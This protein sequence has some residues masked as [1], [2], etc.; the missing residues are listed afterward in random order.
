MASITEGGT[1]PAQKPAKAKG[2][3][4]YRQAIVTRLTHWTWAICL[5]FLLLT[6]LNIFNARP[7]L[8]WGQES[9]FEYDNTIFQIGA[10]AVDGKLR[11]YTDIGGLKFDT[12]GVLGVS[13]TE[14]RPLQRAF[15]PWATIPSG[16]D[17]ATSRVV[18]FFF[19]WLFVAV[20]F[21]WFVFS[22]FNGHIR[23]DVIPTPKDVAG[24]P[25]DV[26]DHATFKFKHARS[27]SP[28]Q[29][30]TYFGVFFVLFP[31]IILTG[32][33]MSPGMDAAWPWL[34][35]IFG[36]RQTARTIHFIVMVLLVL[37][38]IVHIIMVI[39]A[40]PLNE[41]RSMITGYYRTS[42]GTEPDSK[43]RADG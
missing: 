13:G 6:G 22:F 40:G 23:R 37:F 30:L 2:P 38:F 18:H 16:Y 11:G 24:L 5:F 17:L 34:L 25:Q 4:I 36:G 1:M 20:M 33:T 28:L 10:E 43:E 39:L 29:K 32:L 35:D 3:L 9:G 15:P 27:Y 31:L 42:P 21:V 41:L 19:G 14:I 12:T 26:V 7:Q 8:Y